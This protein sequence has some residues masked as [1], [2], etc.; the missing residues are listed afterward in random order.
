MKKFALIFLS[1]LT[2]AGLSASTVGSE[3]PDVKNYNSS[4]SSFLEYT[5]NDNEC[6]RYSSL[7]LKVAPYWDFSFG[8]LM[9]GFV[10]A[11]GHPAN[12]PVEMDKSFEIGINHLIGMTYQVNNFSVKFGFGLDWRNYKITTPDFRFTDNGSFIGAEPYPEGV[13][14]KNSRLKVFSMQIPLL[15]K[16]KMPFRMFGM[17]QSLMAGVTLNYNSHGS[18]VS[19][20]TEADGKKVKMNTSHIGQRR[21]TYDIFGAIGLSNEVGVYV[22]YSPLSVLRGQ[23]QPDFHSFSTGLI[24]FM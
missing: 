6:C 16:Q 8:G 7:S 24:F 20:W 9:F 1:L 18:M 22:R 5:E 23:N 13:T 11:P 3:N 2:A 12:M 17:Q 19:R 15:F 21:F 10:S 4:N 14:P